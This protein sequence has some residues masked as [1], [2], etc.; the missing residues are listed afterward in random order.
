MAQQFLHGPDVVAILEKMG[1][2]TVAQGVAASLL[3][4]ARGSYGLFDRPL[5]AL[6]GPR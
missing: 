3:G 2:E 5:K 4:D 6:W 1:G